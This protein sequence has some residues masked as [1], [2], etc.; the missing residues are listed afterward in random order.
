[1]SDAEPIRLQK[2]LADAGVCSRRAAEAYHPEAVEY[3]AQVYALIF[4]LE[5]RR[6][7]PVAAHA[8]LREAPRIPVIH[9]SAARAGR[10]RKGGL[11]GGPAPAAKWHFDEVFVTING[12]TH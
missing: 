3:L 7:R 5:M 11:G 1:M 2:Y 8:A 9:R 10:L 12:T 4:Q 6:N